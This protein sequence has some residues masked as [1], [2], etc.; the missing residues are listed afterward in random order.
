MAGGV[1]SRVA[2]G[3]AAGGVVTALAALA[4]SA[5]V[6]AQPL[7]PLV[8]GPQALGSGWRVVS[9]PDQSL[10]LTRYT[11]E[12]VDGRLALRLDARASYGNLVHEPPVQPLPRTLTWAWRLQQANPAADLRTR[13]GDD[14]AAKIC[15]SFDLPLKQVP[16]VE[17][18]LLRV[19]R[20]RTGQALPAATLCWVWG[21]RE[22]TG[23][24]IANPYTRRV[25]SIVL[26]GA[27][28]ATGQ[29]LTE[30]RDVAADFRRAFGDES[31]DPPPL[32]AV[33]VAADADNTGATSV[34]FVTDLQF[35]P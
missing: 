11:A 14:A 30:S 32:T 28:D 10:P 25:R 24:L 23:D 1:A 9:L 19:A 16:L 21:G 22:A 2:A 18:T 20:A 13:D 7:P 35:G 31:A 34:A 15:L 17:R 4:T 12:Q 5:A 3:V 26:R 6:A 29:W 8:Q 27:A 33:I